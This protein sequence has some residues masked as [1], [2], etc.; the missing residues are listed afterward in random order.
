M[1]VVGDGFDFTDRLA[2]P[3]IRRS[4]GGLNCFQNLI[5]KKNFFSSESSEWHT[6]EYNCRVIVSA[7]EAEL[8]SINIMKRNRNRCEV[9]GAAN[10]AYNTWRSRK[11]AACQKKNTSLFHEMAATRGLFEGFAPDRGRD[12][13]T[14]PP[15]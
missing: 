11:S 5:L 2:H 7:T 8:Y 10:H 13:N 6:R 4:N 15:P 3:S 12:R 14:S 1:Y 9:R